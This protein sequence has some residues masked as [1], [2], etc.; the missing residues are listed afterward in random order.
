MIDYTLFG[1]AIE[2]YESMGFKLI[3][4]P[5]CVSKEVM[6]ITAPPEVD[7]EKSYCPITEKYL[8]ASAEQSFLQMM[9]D[10]Q[11]EKG[12]YMA[13][14]PCFRDDH[15]DSLHQKYFMKL[16]LIITQP[17]DHL[18]MLSV[19]ANKASFFFDKLV[20]QKQTT[21]QPHKQ[22]IDCCTIK[23]TKDERSVISYDITFSDIEL[24]SYG[25]RRY[26]RSNDEFR[27]IYG[28]G[29]AEPRLSFALSQL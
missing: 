13:V 25:Y 20:W 14:T 24:G 26:Q 7:I 11:L 21:T 28:T 16:E 19:M 12:S 18:D 27:W 10:D 29:L 9:I 8:V 22:L 15:E 2:F 5:W 6:E 17:D 4:V 23:L 3:E 1:K